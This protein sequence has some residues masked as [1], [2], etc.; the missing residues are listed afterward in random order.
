ML[1]P[2]PE[3]STTILRLRFPNLF[4]TKAVAYMLEP[5][6]LK[7]IRWYMWLICPRDTIMK[8]SRIIRTANRGFLTR[9]AGEGRKSTI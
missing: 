1:S 5:Y 9:Q 8:V 3:S 6:G 7:H 4:P 2:Q